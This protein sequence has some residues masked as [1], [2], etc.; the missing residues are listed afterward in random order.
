MNH[1][2]KGLRL[3][4]AHAAEERAA[5][6]VKKFAKAGKTFEFAY[7]GNLQRR[8]IVEDGTATYYLW[9]GL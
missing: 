9:D 8:A 6:L 1:T 2:A 5:G 3:L 7:D 4:Q